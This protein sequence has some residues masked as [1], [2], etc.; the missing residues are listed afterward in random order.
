MNYPPKIK[1]YIPKLIVL[2]AVVINLIALFPETT[3][4]TE[5]NDNVFAFV[6]VNDMNKAWDAG[7]CPLN[8]ISC[9][10]TLSDHWVS[11]FALGF[12]L[13][14]YYQH[15]PHLVPVVIY[16][17]FTLFA[18]SLSLFTVF[19]WFKYLLL[20]IFPIAIYWAARKL[21]IS[22]LPSALSALL[23]PLISTQYLYGTDFNAVVW[24]GSGM[25]TQ[26]WGFVTAPLALGSLYDTVRY[27][28]S[29][30]RSALL[31]ALTFSGH[32]VFGYIV[33]ISAPL[34]VL[35]VFLAQVQNITDTLL[36][37]KRKALVK[38]FFKRLLYLAVPVILAFVFLAYWAV[39]LVI[40]SPWFNGHSFW[41]GRDKF[42]SYGAQIVTQKLANGD[43][44]DANRLPLMTFFVIC[45]FFISLIIFL[46]KKQRFSSE[47]VPASYLLLPLM[48]I[49]WYFL[50]WGRASWGSLINL[51]P[52]A[53]STHL[54]RFINGLH[55][56]GIFL[57]GIGLYWIL[58]RVFKLTRFV[59]T[60]LFSRLK[61]PWTPILGLIFVVG[62]AGI[63]LYPIYTERLSYLRDNAGLIKSANQAFDQDYPDFAKTVAFL[64]KE[65]PQDQGRIWV[66]RPGNWGNDFNVGPT[67]AFMQMSLADI[68][69]SGFL[70]ET[71]S[72]NGDVEQ[73]FSE[74][75]YDHYQTF[76]LN[77]I[78]APPDRQVPSFAQ[79]LA[80]FGKFVVYRIPDI[81]NFEIGTVPFQI[82]ATTSTDFSTLRLWLES[83]WPS[84]H[85]HPAVSLTNKPIANL[86]FR[87]PTMAVLNLD[88]YQVGA[89]N[90]PQ[91]LFAH[92]PFG[93]PPTQSLGQEYATPSGSIQS[94]SH[95]FDQYSAIISVPNSQ[96]E[97]EPTYAIL[98][99]TFQPSWHVLLDNQPAQIVPVAPVFMAV[100]LPPCPDNETSCHHT[101]EFR[102]NTSSLKLSLTLISLL[103][104]FSATFFRK[105]IT[106]FLA[107]V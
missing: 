33:V 42:D 7:H 64:K 30:V 103:S 86:S 97:N 89:Q 47:K 11:T 48:F 6:L 96:L 76:A 91:S 44:F 75:R 69:V 27:R 35:S 78:V 10:S 19:E 83:A 74:A 49:L 54:H 45:G 34:I 63:L 41:D 39:P 100:R 26:L 14:H 43:I 31:L 73:F 50:Y 2:L 17:F 62:T 20:S 59:L 52:L 82:T 79:K 53:E 23:A 9:I 94:E 21:E 8:V 66:G 37:A 1:N 99:A 36:P 51:L 46:Q 80:Q 105:K 12:P 16:R 22:P 24:R 61:S 72:P 56:A 107:K 70:P 93:L 92:N 90:L 55:L 95:R 15:L 29:F 101:L 65:D 81:S 84:F 25:Y 60:H 68:N 104:L 28:R 102:Y 40:D 3:V 88:N 67:H 5:L 87:F 4:K 18:S 38:S 58:E 13:P 106:H 32:L 57:A 71:W 77:Y 85:V 98:K